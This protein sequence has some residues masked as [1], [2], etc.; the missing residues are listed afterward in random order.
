MK[1]G[2]IYILKSKNITGS[3]LI[4][5]EVLEVTEKTYYF[6]NLDNDKDFR[7]FKNV[8]GDRYYIVERMDRTRVQCPDCN[9]T[10]IV[11]TKHPTGGVIVEGICMT[12]NGTRIV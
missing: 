6:K 1:Q 3:Y 8:M 9:G 7:E 2:D 10:G 5:V 11:A 4:K 12:C